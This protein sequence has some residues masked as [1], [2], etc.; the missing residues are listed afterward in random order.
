MIPLVRRARGAVV[1][2]S[3][4]GDEVAAESNQIFAGYV[5]IHP[6]VV[7]CVGGVARA[8]GVGVKNIGD[9]VEIANRGR[10]DRG[11]GFTLAEVMMASTVLVLV[12]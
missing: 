6:P 7:L 3:L 2:M 5:E 12:F 1:R 4:N 9:A 10:K 8:D 11:R